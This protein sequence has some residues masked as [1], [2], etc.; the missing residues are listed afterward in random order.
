MPLSG[1]RA[2]PP[3]RPSGDWE[4][5]WTRPLA[6]KLE[7]LVP[8][9]LDRIEAVDSGKGFAGMRNPGRDS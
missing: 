3:R 5:P 1:C 2:V 8:L 6:K 9:L 7:V 4:N